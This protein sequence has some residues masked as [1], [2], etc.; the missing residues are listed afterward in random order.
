MGWL[1][2]G[3]DKINDLVKVAKEGQKSRQGAWTATEKETVERSCDRV[4]PEL[5]RVQFDRK[6]ALVSNFEGE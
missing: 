2:H 4:R 6:K 3:Q 5:F 1:R